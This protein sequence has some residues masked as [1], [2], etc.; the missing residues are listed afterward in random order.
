MLPFS[1][2]YVIFGSFHIFRRKEAQVGSTY[3]EIRS[4]KERLCIL[5]LIQFYVHMCMYV[6]KIV[7]THTILHKNINK[8]TIMILYHVHLVFFS[9]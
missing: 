7:C 5:N 4:P 9:A 1:N 8:I 2:F 3:P 6:H